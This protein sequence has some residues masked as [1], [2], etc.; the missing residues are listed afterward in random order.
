MKKKNSNVPKYIQE[1]ID[2]IESGKRE[3]CEEQKQLVEY[4]KNVFAT[5]CHTREMAICEKREIKV[6]GIKL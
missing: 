3:S 2:L 6:N 4:V 5:A 1:Y